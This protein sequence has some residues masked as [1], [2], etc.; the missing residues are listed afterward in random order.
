MLLVLWFSL[1]STS[2]SRR[3]RSVICSLPS[4]F[5]LHSAAS[6]YSGFTATGGPHWGRLL[7]PR[8]SDSTPLHKLAS[9]DTSVMNRSMADLAWERLRVTVALVPESSARATRAEWDRSR[10][11]V[12]GSN[13]GNAT[14]RIYGR[15]TSRMTSSVTSPLRDDV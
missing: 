14:R 6:R 4:C 11:N 15:W 5:S 12:H 7:S 10:Y 2:V 9:R 13:D 3:F 1:P 8:L